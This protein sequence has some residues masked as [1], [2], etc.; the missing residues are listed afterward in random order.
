ML[1]MFSATFLHAQL[2][3]TSIT[4]TVTDPSGAVVPGALIS[5]VNKD[6]GVQ[7]EGRSNESGIYLVPSLSPG[8]YT[9]SIEAP[10]FR[11]YVQDLTLV[12]GKVLGLNITLEVGESS[13]T[14]E[15]TAATPLL[16]TTSSDINHLTEQ[17]FVK[18]MPLESDRSGG[19]VRLMPGVA[20]VSE[21]TFEPQL[22]F[23]IAGGQGRSGEYRLDGG[24]VTL[25]ALLTRTIE[26]NPPMEATQ[27]LSV[28]VNAYPA[29]YGHST[30]GVFSITSKSGTNRFHGSVYENFRNNDLDAR[31][32]FS[33]SVPPRKYNVFGGEVDGP[34][35]KNKAFFMFSYEGTRR[36]DGWTRVYQFPSQQEV[37]GDFSDQ[38]APIIDP[39]TGTPFPGKIIPA[40]R[41]DPVGAALANLYPAPNVPGAG[42]A[43]NNYIKNTSDHT[44]ED[45]YFGKV[46]YN[47]TDHDRFGFRFIEYPSSDLTGSAIPNRALDPNALFQSF[48][49]IN[50]SPSWFHTFSPSLFNDVRYT[51]SHRNG[52][53]PSFQPFSVASQVQLTGV[54]ST[55][56]PQINV[57]GLTSLGSSNQWRF[58]RPQITHT[59]DETLTWL[60]GKH[61]LKFGGEYRYSFNRDTWGSLYAGS[62]GFNNVETGNALAAL[63]LG[64]VNTATTNNGDSRTRTDYL[65]VF[66][67][68]DWKVS[69]VLTLNIG[70]RYDLDTPR[71]ERSNHQTGFDPKAINPVSGTPGVITY[72]GVNGAS[73]YISD[74]DIN[75]VGP[76]FGFVWQAPH[77][78]LVLRAGYGLIFGPEY[79]S[80]LG[81]A[82]NAGFG[83]VRALTSPDNGITPAFLLKNG[84]P[85]P[86]LGSGPG[87][88]AVPVGQKPIYSPSFIDPHHQNLYANQ[89]N[90][91]LERQ[92][93]GTMTVQVE[94][95]GNM[96]HKIGSSGT[97]NINETIPSL[98]GA[99]QNQ[100]LRPF[101]Q[102]GNVSWWSPDWGN[103]SYHSLNLIGEKRFSK[104]LNFL[105]T[106]T[107]SKFLDD[108]EAAS[109][110]A[111]SA[112]FGQETYYAHHLDKGLSGNDFRQRLTASFV[113]EF[114]VGKNRT[115]AIN[116]SIL[117]SIVGGWSLGTVAELR[118]GSPWGVYEQTNKLNS[119]SPGQ[120]SNLIGNPNLPS[121]RPRAQRVAEW[122]NT[123]AFAFPGNGVLGNTSKSVGTGP[124]F[125]DFDTSLSKDFH[126]EK[127]TV[128]FRSSFFNIFN[129][130]NFGVPNGSRGS[131]TF[132]QISSTVNQGRFIQLGLRYMF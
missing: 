39:L 65:G 52:Y 96:A 119:F 107:W 104:G 117:N 124:G 103:S 55:G 14:V 34:I 77:N 98:R 122:F 42:P 63:E 94:Y 79:D 87:F 45:S 67:Q 83:D 6:T 58:L 7:V 53:F 72:S 62:F 113:Y 40:G 13:Q 56:T 90:A 82:F 127:Q 20:F 73:K 44:S 27:E 9:F 88:G 2:S 36:V 120:R 38:A 47:L 60:R 118:T 84:M 128:Q 25:N 32:Y 69:P 86:N 23:S 30:G 3:S 31:S 33:R 50:A 74:W 131:A 8:S 1:S 18:N 95:I 129:R 92:L 5:L 115:F 123:A 70:V 46:D 75:N 78:F 21:E 100:A 35:R 24:N 116:S 125:V 28:E 4:G 19:L 61:S 93:T 10:S 48:N 80:S 109:E 17:A 68:D 59:V 41:M 99:T 81:R 121:N 15:V 132:G 12:S 64:W 89:F 16:Q 22:N 29:E 66:V 76:R 111:P 57:T 97:V 106:Y 101:P 49:L 112:N 51:Y 43:T 108:I 110:L 91:S 114:P 71:W 130:P 37:H 126:V 54:P 26:F 11:R 102:Y 85:T 105:A